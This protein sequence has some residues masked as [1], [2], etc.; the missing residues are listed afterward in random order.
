VSN[1]QIGVMLATIGDQ[2]TNRP[3]RLE[4]LAKVLSEI[5]HS[6]AIAAS[7]IRHR[8]RCLF[9][10]DSPDDLTSMHFDEFQKLHPQPVGLPTKVPRPAPGHLQDLAALDLDLDVIE[11]MT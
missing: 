11:R 1:H 10:P 6:I 8:P 2:H 4:A 7:R 9:D 3:T 5:L